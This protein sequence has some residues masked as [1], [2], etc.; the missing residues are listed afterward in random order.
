M[1]KN[2]VTDHSNSPLSTKENTNLIIIGLDIS[3]CVRT[4][5]RAQRFKVRSQNCKETFG[6]FNLAK[7]C[8][9][10]HI[11]NSIEGKTKW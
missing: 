8:G 10:T 3:N 6:S 4:N 1:T 11:L 9:E 7:H 5:V 2:Y